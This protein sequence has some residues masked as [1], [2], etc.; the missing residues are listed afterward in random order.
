MTKIIYR[1][2]NGQSAAEW[3]RQNDVPY[4]SFFDYLEKGL[5]VDEACEKAK[6]AKSLGNVKR[7]IAI[8]LRCLFPLHKSKS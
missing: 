4:G 5:M 7:G 8:F 1:L 3:C 6:K 2:S